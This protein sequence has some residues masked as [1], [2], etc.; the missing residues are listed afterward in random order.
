VKIAPANEI[1]Q[2]IVQLKEFEGKGLFGQVEIIVK[3]NPGELPGITVDKDVIPSYVAVSK[4]MAVEK[5]HGLHTAEKLPEN[6]RQLSKKIVT[7]RAAGVNHLIQPI[8]SDRFKTRTRLPVPPDPSCIPRG[9]SRA[10]SSHAVVRDRYAG[11]TNED[12]AN[13]RRYHRRTQPH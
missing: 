2:N 1:D 11:D 5:G 13:V 7:V 12:Q 6:L 3:V 4:V 10:D 9:L 8:A